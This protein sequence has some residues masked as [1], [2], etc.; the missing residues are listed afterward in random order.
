M[1][2]KEHN[3]PKKAP[4]RFTYPVDAFVELNGTRQI[5]QIQN[6]SKT[7]IQFYSNVFNRELRTNTVDV[8]RFT[9]WSNGVACAGSSFA[10][11][12]GRI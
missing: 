2:N 6:I 7:G 11:T 10:S 1:M 5:I 4:K 3:V 12:S 9:A 8:A